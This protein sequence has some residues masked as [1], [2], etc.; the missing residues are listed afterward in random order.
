MNKVF[1]LLTYIIYFYFDCAFI[2]GK[3]DK[4][5][6][7]VRTVYTSHQ[8]LL[9]EEYFKSV[10]IHPN[11]EQYRNLSRHINVDVQTLRVSD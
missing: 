6:R 5:R 8:K 2:L 1:L 11:A 9:L 7:K 10:T 3:V 4:K